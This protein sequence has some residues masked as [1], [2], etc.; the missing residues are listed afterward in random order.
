VGATTAETAS[1]LLVVKT[2]PVIR[3]VSIEEIRAEVARFEAAHPGIG[4]DNYPDVFRD[5]RGE[6]IE[7]EEF[8]DVCRLYS[9]LA[10]NG[11]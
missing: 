4:A 9:V 1:P 3:H 11:E 10:A 8:F 5:D 6:L 2:K 7:T